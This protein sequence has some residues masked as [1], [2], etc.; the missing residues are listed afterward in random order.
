MNGSAAATPPSFPGW[1]TETYRA[2]QHIEHLRS[3]QQ[4]TH[5]TA[6]D[7]TETAPK[8]S[9]TSHSEPVERK[10]RR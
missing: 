8:T 5:Q 10:C 1:V 3:A 4:P 6:L 7:S 9:E 2:L